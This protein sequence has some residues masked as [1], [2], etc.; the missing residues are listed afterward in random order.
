MANRELIDRIL[1][2]YG[3][4]A[5]AVSTVQKGYRSKV[6]TVQTTGGETLNLILFKREPDIV[7]KIQNA[8]RVGGFLAKQGLPARRTLDKRIT[9]LY[10]P[11]QVT[12]G[13]LYNH[14]P[15]QTIPWEAYSMKHLKQ[16]GTMMSDMHATLQPLKRGNLPGIAEEYSVICRHMQTYFD[17]TGVQQALQAKLRLQPPRK[18]PDYE[19]LLAELATA[20]HQQVLH[21]DFVRGNILFNDSA[22]ITGILDFEKTAWGSTAFDIA[23]TL[24]FLLVDCKYKSEL[25]V[26]KYF[27]HSGYNKRGKAHFDNWPLLEQLVDLFLTYDFYKFL[28]HNPYEFLIENE[29]F[30]RTR[31]LLQQRGLIE[32]AQPSTSVKKL[33]K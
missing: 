8:N 10:S 26:R 11:R 20:D 25:K 13:A 22:E 32:T 23:R 9:T 16:L 2:Q 28:R 12:Y 6:Y 3:K 5:K 31:N 18:L 27:L 4:S 21:M 7:A 19:V 29:H 17:Q 33:L 24:A 1:E 30:V 14:L 15:G